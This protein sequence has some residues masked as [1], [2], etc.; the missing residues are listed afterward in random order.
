MKDFLQ[1]HLAVSSPVAAPVV[2]VVT[3][4]G[5]LALPLPA[6][7]NAPFSE[8]PARTDPAQT[9][10]EPDPGSHR[11]YMAGGK[12][13]LDVVMVLATLPLSLAIIAAAAVLLWLEGGNPFYRQQR[14]G[15]GGR[16]FAIWKLRTMVRDADA[17]LAEYLDR[18]PALRHEWDST[19]KLKKDPRITRIG[20]LLRATSIDELPQLWNVLKGDM[21]LVGPRPMMP[22]QLP[23]YGDATAYFAL[24]PG[25]TGIWQVSA[26]N[27]HLFSCR[28]QFDALYFA[29]A[30]LW[31]D[32]VL[33]F[34]TVGVVVRRTGY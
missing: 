27:E 10:A 8:A 19:Q 1:E 7:R 30:S 11:W 12:R 3:A 33:M 21:S 18:D 23:I 34:K 28:A 14:L 20:A 31:G 9:P 26:R 5:F 24:K 2:P 4:S 25:I 32:L 16:A 17:R 15:Q 13:T 6:N 29:T 22:E